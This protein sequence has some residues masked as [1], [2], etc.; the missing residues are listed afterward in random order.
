[1]SGNTPTEMGRHERQVRAQI[2]R[3][4]RS[5]PM[6]QV[7]GE[8]DRALR[9]GNFG[10]AVLWSRRLDRCDRFTDAFMNA[11]VS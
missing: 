1:M 11:E 7:Q 2:D 3:K 4:L 8:I 5:L 10:A 6:D 9:A